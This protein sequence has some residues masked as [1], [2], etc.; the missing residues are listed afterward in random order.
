M[1][2][3]AKEELGE[4]VSLAAVLACVVVYFIFMTLFWI[5]ISAI[6]Y[7]ILHAFGLSLNFL[8]W[9]IV[10]LPLVLIL[11]DAIQDWGEQTFLR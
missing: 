10:N 7:P 11:D 4:D 9:M 3:A 8:L 2:E 1:V 6:T 5:A